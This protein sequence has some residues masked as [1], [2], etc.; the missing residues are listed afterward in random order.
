MGMHS[1]K[2]TGP[3]APLDTFYFR[4]SLS[5]FPLCTVFSLRWLVNSE[6][7]LSNMRSQPLLIAHCPHG[8]CLFKLSRRTYALRNSKFLS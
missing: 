5:E 6:A 7:H 1:R 8:V 3:M 2:L 4:L